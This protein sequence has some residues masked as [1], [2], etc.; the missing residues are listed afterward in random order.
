MAFMEAW[1]TGMPVVAI[2]KSLAGF[3]IEVPQLIANGVN[4][5]TSDSLAELRRYISALLEDYGL[6]KKISSEGRKKAIELFDKGK[7]KGQW[8]CFFDSL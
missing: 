3:N 5:F 2:G 8:K 7:I 1:M 4:G 6:A